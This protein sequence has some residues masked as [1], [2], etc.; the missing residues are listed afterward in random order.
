MLMR[1]LIRP[2]RKALSQME[3]LPFLEKISPTVAHN[4]SVEDLGGYLASQQISFQCA[5]EVATMLQ[6]GWTEK[7]TA[8]LMETWLRDH[9]IKHFFH[10][11][12]VWWGSRTRF[13]GVKNYRDYQPTSRRLLEGELFILDV[14]P[15]VNGYISD[16]GYSGVIGD[17]KSFTTGRD[18]LRSLRE[19]IPALVSELCSGAAVW[20]AIDEKIKAAGYDNIHAKYPFGV[21]GHRVHK[22]KNN[23]DLSFLHFG[24][25]SYWEFTSRGLFGQ[26]L[27]ANHIGNMN[28]LWAIEPH[29]GGKDFGMKFEEI[30]VVENGVARWLDQET[31]WSR[32]KSLVGDVIGAYK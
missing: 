23:G 27:E 12:F 11:P 22:A 2:V 25:Q 6:P 15:I 1:D 19:D 24:W 29:I 28:G 21:L 18:F 16:I 3:S 10:K 9:G 30:L 20:K 14:A 31:C 7:D 8:R 4:Q 5:S 17:S 13:E 32:Q 26:L